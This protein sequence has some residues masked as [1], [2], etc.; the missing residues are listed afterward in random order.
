VPDSLQAER[1]VR[2]L[3]SALKSSLGQDAIVGG[4]TA[5]AA[6]LIDR[7]DARTPIV[8]LT[9][10]LAEMMLLTALL[11]A[12]IVALKAA[13]TSFLTVATTLGLLTLL[14]GSNGGLGFFVPLTLISVVF[15][16]STDYEVFLLSRIK[17]E[18]AS[19]SSNLASLRRGVIATARSITLAGLTMSAV[20]FAF[21]SSP[22]LSFA[23]LGIGM[24]VAVVLDV[25]V[26][27]CLLVPAMVALLGDR[28]WWWPQRARRAVQVPVR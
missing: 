18:Y 17:E 1:Q 4:P 5:E 25:T 19:G 11:R 7:L 22:L 10:A 23:Q 26:V 24:G 27:R 8:I 15:G 12:P 20:F 28:N 6:D 13:A 16:L 21:A 3:R 9:I 14:Y 2:S